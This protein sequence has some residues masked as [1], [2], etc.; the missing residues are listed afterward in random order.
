MKGKLQKLHI[1]QEVLAAITQV[2]LRCQ[3]NYD[4]LKNTNS[5]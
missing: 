5:K 2:S 4:K 1:T 3:Q